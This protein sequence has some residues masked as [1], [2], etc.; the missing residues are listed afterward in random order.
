MPVV[1]VTVVKVFDIQGISTKK[2]FCVYVRLQGQSMRTTTASGSTTDVNFK[3]RF[4]FQY[5]P[6]GQSREK[7]HLFVEVWSK[8]F[9]GQSCVSIAWVDMAAQFF[10]RGQPITFNLSGSFEGRRATA[11]VMITPVDF[12]MHQPWYPTAP[13]MAMAIPMPPTPPGAAAAGTVMPAQPDHPY[14]T[15]QYYSN[16]CAQ[17][18]CTPSPAAPPVLGTLPPPLY[19]PANAQQPYTWDPQPGPKPL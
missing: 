14:P 13:P 10:M 19:G 15:A 3:E 2:N 11:A 12:G 7:N 16:S 18:T 9:L 4:R 8:S 5:H 17:D 1:D 6:D